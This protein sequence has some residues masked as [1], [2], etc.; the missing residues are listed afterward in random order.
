LLGAGDHVPVIPLLEVVGRALKLAPEHIALTAVNVGVTFGLTVT[1]VAALDADTQPLASVAITVYDAAAEAVYVEPV[2]TTDEPLL[3]EYVAPPL[4]VKTTLPP[5]QKV[6]GPPAEIVAV[7][8]GLT[9]TTVAALV[10]VHILT[11]VCIT[12]YEP[13]VVNVAFLAVAPLLHMYDP[14]VLAD[15]LK[16]TVP[17]VQKVVVLFGAVEVIEIVGVAGKA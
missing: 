1:T 16:V 5:E 11:F 10:A 4:A 7:G 13:D 6:V 14:A 8:N 2:P 17:P 3:Q 12:V 15:D 9:V